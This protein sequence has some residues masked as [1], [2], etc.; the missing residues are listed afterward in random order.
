MDNILDRTCE[1]VDNCKHSQSKAPCSGL[2]ACGL[3]NC[4]GIRKYFVD[5]W[6]VVK[7]PHHHFK[8]CLP[9]D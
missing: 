2:R 5:L 8:H 7:K 4:S 6:T 1:F 9:T 3:F